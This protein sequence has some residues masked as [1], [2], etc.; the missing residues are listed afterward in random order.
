MLD[1]LSLS[2]TAPLILPHHTNQVKEKMGAGCMSNV[3]NVQHERKGFL[4]E[5][6]EKGEKGRN[7]GTVGI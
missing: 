7:Q 2:I 5:E 1:L 4:L 3:R 6:R